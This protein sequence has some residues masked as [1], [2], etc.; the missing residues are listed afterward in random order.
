MSLVKEDLSSHWYAR[1]GKP[2]HDA[3]LRHARKELLLPSVTTVLKVWPKPQLDMWKIEQAIVSALTLPR[4][5]DE[6][7][8]AFARRV[9]ED[10]GQEVKQ[11]AKE[12]TNLHELLNVRLVTG[13]WPEARGYAPWMMSYETWIKDNI[14]EVVQS[15]QVT[16][17]EKY[18]YAG[19]IDLIAKTKRWG[20]CVLDFKSQSVKA[21]PNF[22]NT[23]AMQL[24]AYAKSFDDNLFTSH[25]PVV[26][27]LVSLVL[28]RKKPDQPHVKVW[29][30]EEAHHAWLCFFAAMRLWTLDKAYYPAPVWEL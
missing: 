1:D 26:D 24:A 16:T 6:Q 14:V 22:Y 29:N 13:S 3:N 8:D 4:L 15:E 23:F 21:K 7:D 20:L 18:G 2:R 25:T 27:N 10:M 5:P 12:G 17:N 9:V 30:A 11:A 19:T 28:D